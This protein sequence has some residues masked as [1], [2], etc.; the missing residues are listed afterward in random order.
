MRDEQ[1]GKA[2]QRKEWKLCVTFSISIS[3]A[4]DKQ[5]L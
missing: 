3:I 2:E 4:S 1:A 5:E